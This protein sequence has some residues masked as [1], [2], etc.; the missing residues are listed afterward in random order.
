MLRAELGSEGARREGVTRGRLG[1]RVGRAQSVTVR[2]ALGTEDVVAFSLFLEVPLMSKV[3]RGL[4]AAHL[5]EC[6][7]ETS[8][9]S[10]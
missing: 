4:P 3:L 2:Q 8:S 1:G 7:V 9:T 5:K 10:T 6:H